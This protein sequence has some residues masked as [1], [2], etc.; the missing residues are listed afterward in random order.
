[1]PTNFPTSVD[2]FTNP[3]ANDSLNLPSHSTQHANA[4][5]AIEAIEAAIISPATYP[6]Q[7][8]NGTTATVRPLPFATLAGVAS[9]PT[10]GTTFSTVTVTFSSATRF[11][12]T[13]IFSLGF[14]GNGSYGYVVT[15]VNPTTTGFTA[16]GDR[17]GAGNFTSVSTFGYVCVQMTS[18]S[19]AG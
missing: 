1:M 8:V 15:I 7:L 2:N 4:N 3:T 9:L 17:V 6:N 12:Q 5:D 14:G 18:A 10:A 11:T 13:P 19:A 16:I